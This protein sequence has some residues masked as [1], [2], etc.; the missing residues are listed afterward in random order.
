MYFFAG[1]FNYLIFMLPAIIVSMVAQLSVKSTFAKYSKVRSQRNLTGAQAAYRVLQSAAISGVNIRPVAGELTD[2][3]DPRTNIINLSQNVYNDTSVAALG[4][5]AHEAGHALQYAE[6]YLPLKLRSVMVPIT[7]VGST[8]S[9]PIILFGYFFSFQPMVT[10][11]ILLFSLVVLFS[12][13]TLPVEFNASARA[14]SC[15]EAS[16]TLSSD[17]LIGAKRVLRAAAMTYLASTFTA[18]WQLLRLVLLFGQR[19]D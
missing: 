3:F 7:Q 10:A 15:L 1:Y 16:A 18:L 11:G 12:I 17:E 8:L 13:V 4:V 14:I 6:H 2:N 9:L 5:A 19:R